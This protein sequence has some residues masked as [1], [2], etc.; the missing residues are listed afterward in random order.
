MRPLEIL[1][2]LANLVLLALL[3][4]PRL[5]PQRSMKYLVLLPA[6]IGVAQVA[7]EGRRWQMVPAYALSIVPVLVLLARPTI[8]VGAHAGRVG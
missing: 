7:V 6:L 4:I 3:A 1:L 8:P 2:S 5:Q